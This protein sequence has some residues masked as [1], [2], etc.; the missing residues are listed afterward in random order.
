MISRRTMLRGVLGGSAF[1]LGLPLLE[2]MLNNH[3]TA[4]AQGVALPKRYGLFFWGE[5]LPL[6]LRHN[7]TPDG[8][9]NQNFGFQSTDADY[10]TPTTTG[11]D[12]ALTELLTPLANHKANINVVTGLKVKTDIPADPPGQEDGHM[13][14]VSC[15]LSAD[16]PMSDGFDHSVGRFKLNRPTLDQFIATHPQFYTDGA[17]SFRSLELGMGEAFLNTTG[18]WICASHSGPDLLNLPIRDPKKLFDFVFAVPPDTSELGRR[19]S[20]LDVVA[21]DARRLMAR[22]G[23]RDKQRLD[24]HLTH[25]NDIEHRLQNGTGV[26]AVPA[27]PAAFPDREF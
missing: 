20:V 19:V 14:G 3:G 22:L 26:C 23:A 10:W 27:E 1:Y 15:A 13:R 5:G 6:N 21:N 8:E 16:R 24:E 11:T 4:L 7:V 2:Q 12:W 17:P 18:T 9:A 25:L